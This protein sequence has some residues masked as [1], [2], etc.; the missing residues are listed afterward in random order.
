MDRVSRQIHQ[1][2]DETKCLEGKTIDDQS[3]R[4]LRLSWACDDGISKHYWDD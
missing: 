1:R 3:R 4:F 2:D